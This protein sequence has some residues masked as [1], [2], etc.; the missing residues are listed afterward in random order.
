MPVISGSNIVYN[1][2]TAQGTNYT[3]SYLGSDGKYF[4]GLPWA[5]ISGDYVRTLNIKNGTQLTDM[6]G[7][8]YILKQSV[9]RKAPSTVNSSNCATLTAA[10][11]N[12]ETNISAKTS[13][14]IAAIDSSWVKPVVDDNPK[15]IDGVIQ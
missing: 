14:D 4:W 10:A 13:A 2:G 12:A 9:I 6:N 3:P 5:N 11:V 1:D 7:V 8:S 15:V